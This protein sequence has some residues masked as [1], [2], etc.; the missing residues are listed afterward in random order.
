MISIDNNYIDL[1]F[2]DLATIKKKLCNEQ[3]Q[4]KLTVWQRRSPDDKMQ[5]V[6]MPPSNKKLW[7][8][9]VEQCLIYKT[10]GEFGLTLMR[11]KVSWT[12]DTL[13]VMSI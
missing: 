12:L 3:N 9:Q 5:N 1:T 13:Y 8:H 6:E 4:V 2:I 10:N 7:P 11:I